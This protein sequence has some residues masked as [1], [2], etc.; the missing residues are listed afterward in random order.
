MSEP[1]TQE[2]CRKAHL[3]LQKDVIVLSE[4]QVVTTTTLEGL[5]KSLDK[6]IR[7]MVL[8]QERDRKSEEVTTEYKK[9]VVEQYK[10]ITQIATQDLRITR[11]EKIVYRVVTM[12]L[13]GLLG[14]I[15]NAVMIHN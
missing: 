15:L 6:L 1:T 10:I 14:G 9:T 2:E 3:A 11:V 5:V 7:Q 8:Q 4:K 12:A 13:A